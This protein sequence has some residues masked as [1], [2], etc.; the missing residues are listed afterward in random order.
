MLDLLPQPFPGQRAFAHA[1]D[2]PHQEQHV[3][4]GRPLVQRLQ[5]AAPA[6]EVMRLNVGM[7]KIRPQPRVVAQAAAAALLAFQ[8]GDVMLDLVA[9]QRLE[10]LIAQV[11]GRIEEADHVPRA[12]FLF[13]PVELEHL[14]GVGLDIPG[15]HLMLIRHDEDQHRD[16]ALHRVAVFQF[17]DRQAFRVAQWVIRHI[18]VAQR[19]DA[20]VDLGIRDQVERIFHRV[21]DGGDIAF[22]H[23]REEIGPPDSVAGQLPVPVEVAGGAA[24]EHIAVAGVGHE[25][26]V[27][28]KTLRWAQYTVPLPDGG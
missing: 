4:R 23:E 25:G 21:L 16:V 3:L 10:D 9:L 27:F 12:Q 6:D 15:S 11:I 1:A 28:Y 22:H 14:G 8:P 2:G 5:F 13:Q 18:A 20:D 7:G 17:G 24:D 19:E 26:L